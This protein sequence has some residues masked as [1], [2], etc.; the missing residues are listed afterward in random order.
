MNDECG[1]MKSEEGEKAWSMGIR[2]TG[3]KV[4][5][6]G[7]GELWIME[8]EEIAA[9]HDNGFCRGRYRYRYRKLWVLPRMTFPSIFFRPSPSCR[10][11][12]PEADTDTDP[13]PD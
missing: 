9:R 10:L 12:E 5:N 4:G 6:S 11:S 7:I 13:D 8:Q 2:G 1:M 3:K